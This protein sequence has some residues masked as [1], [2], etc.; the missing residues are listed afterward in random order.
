M[1]KFIK[2]GLAIVV[3]GFM[4]SFWG[5]QMQHASA[6]GLH[7][8]P[9]AHPD[10]DC[11]V[12][13]FVDDPDPVAETGP[14]TYEIYVKNY[15][16]IAGD[17]TEGVLTVSID[18]H[19][20]YVDYQAP[21]GVTCTQGDADPADGVFEV[22][23]DMG[24]L[25]PLD[26]KVVTI[27]LTA[28][29]GVGT[30]SSTATIACTS[31]GNPANDS[32]N[33]QTTVRKGADIQLTKTVTPDV[34]ADGGLVVYTIQVHNSGPSTVPDLEFHDTLPAGVVFVADDASPPADDDHLWTC[35]AT[36]QDVTCTYDENTGGELA[37]GADLVFHFRA[38]A[39][40]VSMAISSIMRMLALCLQ[41]G[42][43][44]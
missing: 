33:N 39:E 17:D 27:D 35:S 16:S 14:L 4:A 22:T 41:R 21:T 1:G 20:T 9:M 24:V 36:G 28:P 6:Q 44:Y 11:G 3:V 2:L 25:H 5:K 38:Q 26:E 15:S 10:A 34:V 37:S 32:E 18:D 19:F 13:V 7:P 12:P 29:V 40:Q 23:C 43:R 8:Q 31:D 30:Y 42:I